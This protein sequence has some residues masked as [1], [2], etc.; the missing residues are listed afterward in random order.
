MPHLSRLTS[1]PLHGRVDGRFGD[2]LA[3][4][5]QPPA[6]SRDRAR[7]VDGVGRYPGDVKHRLRPVPEALSPADAFLGGV[8]IAIHPRVDRLAE[9]WG[10][11]R[12]ELHHGL[13]HEHL[14]SRALQIPHAPVDENGMVAHPLDALTHQNAPRDL[15]EVQ[16]HPGT[17][18]DVHLVDARLPLDQPVDAVHLDVAVGHGGK[19][20]EVSVLGGKEHVGDH[21][22]H[23]E[24]LPAHV[25][26]RLD[27]GLV[28]EVPHHDTGLVLLDYLHADE[29][30][31]EL[32]GRLEH[33]PADGLFREHRDRVV[34]CYVGADQPPVEGVPVQ[35]GVHVDGLPVIYF[36]WLSRTHAEQQPAVWQGGQHDGVV[37]LETHGVRPRLGKGY[38]E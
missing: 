1:L 6:A 10:H 38:H 17:Q 30:L 5:C 8:D 25:F 29:G 22:L 15:P 33:P 7:G 20:L 23:E 31:R 36:G 2:I 13:A 14:G 28:D 21:P 32:R 37:L 34:P 24:V 9:Q 4:L 11:L 3:V 27:L 18:R 19:P 12:A 26:L 16:P 35:D